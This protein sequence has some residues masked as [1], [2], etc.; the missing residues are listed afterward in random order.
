MKNKIKIRFVILLL[1]FGIILISG[2][3][4]EIIWTKYPGN[5]VL[6]ENPDTAW[7]HWSSDPYVMRDGD[8]YK[9]WYGTNRNGSWTQIGYAI[10]S[11]G[12]NWARHIE[13]VL[14]LGSYGSWDDEDVETPTVVKYNGMYHMWYCAR[15][16]PEGSP[17]SPE[18]TYRIGHATSPD[19]INWNKDP[20]N[21]VILLGDQNINEWDWA[22]TAE[23]A[24][25]VEDGIFKMWY[26]GGNI[27]NNKFYLHIG[28]AI[29]SDGSQWSKYSENPVLSSMK[30]NGI[31]T[32]SILHTGNGYELW[33]S[34]FNERKGIPA[35]PFRYA[36]SSDG[37]NWTM[38]PGNVL[39]K[40][41]LGAWD[42]T[43]VFGPTVL[44]EN[45]EYNMWYS[46]FRINL[47]FSVNFGI[48]Y[49]TNDLP[50]FSISPLSCFRD[51]E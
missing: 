4:E 16:E 21:P 47:D 3:V 51:L 12:I 23:P 20:Y 36:F 5:P 35:G 31:T 38:Y 6:S 45:N 49:A 44:L 34:I 9:M 42:S 15:G 32:P 24:V 17:W 39:K 41:P 40:G 11:D 13:P 48:G 14:P 19:G 7:D 25:I 1:I 2:C 29:S 33:Y 27:I 37:I 30:Y 43:G 10:S 46:G 28:Y 22:V 26:V 8:I 50:S 18:A